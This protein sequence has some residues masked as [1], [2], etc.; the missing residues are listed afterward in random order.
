MEKV[1][2][3]KKTIKINAEVHKL[4]KSQAAYEGKN[5]NDLANQILNNYLVKHS[6]FRKALKAKEVKK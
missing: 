1:E 6:I 3:G 5:L 4:L 2:S